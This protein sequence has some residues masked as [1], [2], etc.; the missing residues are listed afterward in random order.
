M[1]FCNHLAMMANFQENCYQRTRYYFPAHLQYET[2]FIS[3][4]TILPLYLRERNYALSMRGPIAHRKSRDRN[5][6][7]IVR[8]KSSSCRGEF[9]GRV[10]QVST[11]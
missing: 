6:A 9:L 10:A 7:G 3:D 11:E 4:I 2:L 1:V 8:V 5:I